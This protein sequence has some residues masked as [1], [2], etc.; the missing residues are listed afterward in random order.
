[1]VLDGIDPFVKSEAPM[2]ADGAAC[3]K[4]GM[5]RCEDLLNLFRY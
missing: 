3:G 1:M 5:I 2:Q 4:G